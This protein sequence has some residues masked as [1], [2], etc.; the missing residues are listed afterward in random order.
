M[1]YK[2]FQK[3]TF[4]PYKILFYLS[5]IYSIHLSIYIVYLSIYLY[6][7]SIYLFVY[8]LSIFQT[9]LTFIYFIY[10]FLFFTA[11]ID[12]SSLLIVEQLILSFQQFLIFSFFA[13]KR[14]PNEHNDENDDYDNVTSF[15]YL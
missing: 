1:F 4:L 13:R 12:D 6:V 7:V 15:R 2:F 8:N 10:L 5:I 3:L 11:P 14:S 9:F